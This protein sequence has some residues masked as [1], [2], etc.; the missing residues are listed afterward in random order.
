MAKTADPRTLAFHVDAVKKCDRVF[1]DAF[2]GVSRM[3]LDAGIRKVTV[4]GK[5]TYQF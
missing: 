1:E 3:I 5:T 2:Q 4:K